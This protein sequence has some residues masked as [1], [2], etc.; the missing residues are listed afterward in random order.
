MSRM[1]LQVSSLTS[2]VSSLKSARDEGAEPSEM[3]LET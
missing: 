2:E 1:K 3:T